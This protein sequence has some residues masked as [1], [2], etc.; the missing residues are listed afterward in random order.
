MNADYRKWGSCY[1]FQNTRYLYWNML[2][3]GDFDLMLP[4]FD[5]YYNMLEI[6]KIMTKQYYGHDKVFFS[7]TVNFFGLYAPEDFG[8]NHEGKESENEYARYY[9]QGGLELS[10]M[11]LR[12]YEYTN[13]EQLLRQK[14][15]P[16]VEEVLRFYAQ[17]Y[18]RNAEGILEITPSHALGTYWEHVKNPVDVIAGLRCVVSALLTLPERL[19]TL[20]QRKEWAILYQ[21]IP[22]IQ[23]GQEGEHSYI[24]PAHEYEEKRHNTENPELYPVFPY[25]FYG[26]EKEN[27]EL[28]IRTYERHVGRENFCWRQNGIHAAYLALANEAKQSV[29]EHFEN[30]ESEES[31]QDIGQKDLIGHQT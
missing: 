3:A 30:V 7:E 25:H 11:M 22:N 31:F 2:A 1:W 28:V 27:M 12:Y 29:I 9:W 5:M 8:W 4:L 23:I 14:I 13:D 10:A 26:M 16:I 24:K 21:A 20:E 17:H 15:L 19:T 18:E 6:H